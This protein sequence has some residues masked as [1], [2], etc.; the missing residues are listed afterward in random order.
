MN[1]CVDTPADGEVVVVDDDGLTLEVVRRTLRG[2][3]VQITCF[4]DEQIAMEYLRTHDAKVL[5]VDQRMPAINGVDLLQELANEGVK[6][7]LRLF[8]CSVADLPAD[9]LAKARALGAETI[10]KSLYRDKEGMLA[11]F[12]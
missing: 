8:L 4:R 10:N 3:G 11:L 9:D 7:P 2:T 1:M 12:R 5:L 6:L